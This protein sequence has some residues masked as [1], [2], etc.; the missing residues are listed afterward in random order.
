MA[1]VRGRRSGPDG[2]LQ[3]SCDC[4]GST[5]SIGAVSRCLS[6]ADGTRIRRCFLLSSTLLYEVAT[7]ATTPWPHRRVWRVRIFH[8]WIW[9]GLTHRRDPGRPACRR[10][11]IPMPKERRPMSRPPS[12][13]LLEKELFYWAW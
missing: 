13:L 12:S 5:V 11:A 1:S 6:E 10:G 7:L 4:V 8:F 9:R 3:K 2:D